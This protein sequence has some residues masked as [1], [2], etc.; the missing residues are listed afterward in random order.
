MIFA[1]PN[2]GTGGAGMS[3]LLQGMMA[4][5]QSRQNDEK[6]DWLRTNQ[7]RQTEQYEQKEAFGRIGIFEDMI[8][9][10]NYDQKLVDSN[11][12]WFK[13]STNFNDTQF[14]LSD[15]ETYK[16]NNGNYTN[17]FLNKYKADTGKDWLVGSESEAD[18]ADMQNY[19]SNDG[20]QLMMNGKIFDPDTFSA[21]SSSYK[22]YK[23]QQD[24]ARRL[25]EAQIVK[26]LGGS[27]GPSDLDMYT[28]L[29]ANKNKTPKQQIKYEALQ[30][31]LKMTQDANID[32]LTGEFGTTLEK[33]QNGE[34]V[35][36]DIQNYALSAQAKAKQTFTKREEHATAVAGSKRMVETYNEL[37]KLTEKY[38]T[39]DGISKGAEAEILKTMSAEDFAKLEKD[40]QIAVTANAIKQTQVFSKVFRV[41]KEESGAAFT[42]EEFA[43][44]L[45]TIVGGDPS[46]INEQTLMAAFGTYTAEALK[47][48]KAG[49][50]EISN[51]YMGDKLALIDSYNKGTRG[52]RAPTPES[53]ITPN[54]GMTAGEGV[55][56][57]T[58]EE[59]KGLVQLASD[60]LGGFKDAVVGKDNKPQ[61]IKDV[62][63]DGKSNGLERRK[64]YA[65]VL[66]ELEDEKLYSNADVKQWF[67]DHKEDMT[68]KEQTT[69][70]KKFSSRG[71]K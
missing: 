67:V 9:S 44:R 3:G 21:G 55:K 56:E 27:D 39:K 48:T 28:E 66:R 59:S 8:K 38:D 12:E 57:V 33:A 45:A 49:L 69:F 5:K 50:G 19:V 15:M 34:D 60:V 29:K 4:G 25:Q 37:S 35:S 7:E 6:M 20:R 31:K 63:F 54:G 70:I 52:F 16:D 36:Q 11:N 17:E 32:K 62:K 53:N 46:K 51:L 18:V 1:T 22:K 2:R 10:K 40:E 30:K 58:S 68:T 61:T 42:D 71:D 24:L 13:N 26:A 43:R 14:S 64:A 41:V 65:G 23:E 47:N